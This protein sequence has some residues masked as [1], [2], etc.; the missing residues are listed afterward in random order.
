MIELLR[1]GAN[2]MAMDW[3]G[4][5]NPLHVAVANGRPRSIEILLTAGVGVDSFDEEKCWTPL[6]YAA[7]SGKLYAVK[8][9][10]QAE[11]ESNS[12]VLQHS[13]HSPLHLA[14][15]MGHADVVRELLDAGARIDHLNNVGQ[16][17]LELAVGCNELK[18]AQA[19]LSVDVPS[20]ILGRALHQA[21]SVRGDN[22]ALVRALLRAGA[23]ANSACYR[24][25]MTPLHVACGKVHLEYVKE[26]LVWGADECA[27]KPG[28]CRESVIGRDVWNVPTDPD[29]LEKVSSLVELGPGSSLAMQTFMQRTRLV[30]QE[31]RRAAAFRAWRRRG[32]LVMMALR[33]DDDVTRKSKKRKTSMGCSTS[34]EG[35]A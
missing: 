23:N 32:W 8:S 5:V 9:L 13:G 26:L 31:L 14:A 22:H 12:W 17:A 1:Y 2:P 11:A 35:A 21:V 27:G 15:K 3:P 20:R 18:A 29:D 19:C 6:H 28:N 24:Q 4:G 7:S 10:L 16:S 25:S 33:G 30:R 34:N